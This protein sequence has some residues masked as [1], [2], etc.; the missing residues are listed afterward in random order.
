[1]TTLKKIPI[2]LSLPGGREFYEA[3]IKYGRRGRW[4]PADM[5]RL[6][7]GECD[8]YS[9]QNVYGYQGITQIGTNELASLGYHSGSRGDFWKLPAA[10]QLEF[11]YK[12]FEEWRVRKG[13][14]RWEDAG[15]LWEANL[16]P[17]HLGS[18]IVYVKVT[19]KAQYNANAWLDVNGDGIIKRWEL[20]EALTRAA[21]SEHN[22]PKYLLG[23]A[24]LEVVKMQLTLQEQVASKPDPRYDFSVVD[25]LHVDETTAIDPTDP[26]GLKRPGE[27]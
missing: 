23:L 2:D 8:F 6:I 12:Y 14:Q 4:N 10:E 7:A 15:H 11:T 25:P 17:A 9:V 3:L 21:N 20:D 13:I 26:L 24:N 19:H 5:L 1:M 27:R 16:A 22:K 18:D